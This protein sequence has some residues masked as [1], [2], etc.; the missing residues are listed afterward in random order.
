M[1]SYV[2]TCNYLPSDH[3][4][5]VCSLDIP[6]PMLTKKHIKFRDLKH[7]NTQ[8]WR[9]DLQSSLSKCTSTH[10]ESITDHFNCTLHELWDKHAP[11][12]SRKIRLRP[13]APWYTDTLRKMKR[14]KCRLKRKN[15]KTRL[16]IHRQMYRAMCD[17]Y[18]T[19]LDTAKSEYYKAKISNSN[20]QQLFRLI[21][22]L[23]KVKVIP[24]LP[25]CDSLPQ[26]AEA[27]SNYFLKKIY[28]LRDDLE[29]SKMSS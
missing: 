15:V 6:R 10:A 13:N 5:V 20:N 26:L 14:E 17:D 29:S 21:D 11:V 23:F 8:L 3:F 18:T 16:E 2:E 4:T 22:S 1:L 19:A 9:E 27:F 24:P 28:T 7:I 25:S 12:T